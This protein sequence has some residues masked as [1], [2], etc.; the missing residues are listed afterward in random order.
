MRVD[1]NGAVSPVY[2]EMG[3]QGEPKTRS[4][5]KCGHQIAI[6]TAHWNQDPHNNPV[7]SEFEWL[8]PPSPQFQTHLIFQNHL[9][10]PSRATD[11]DT[12]KMKIFQ[13]I[14]LRAC[15]SRRSAGLAYQ[16]R[17]ISSVEHKKE[18]WDV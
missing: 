9:A 6:S 13:Y 4:D 11:H 8:T 16:A 3:S 5:M 12:A 17:R 15:A 1:F 7:Y 10:H 18:K 14:K 2:I